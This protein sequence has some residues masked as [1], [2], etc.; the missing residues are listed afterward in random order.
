ML[1]NSKYNQMED[2]KNTYF[3]SFHFPSF[4][5][6]I[7]YGNKISGWL[8]IKPTISLLLLI[9]NKKKTWKLM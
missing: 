4:L 5:F 9:I 7:N 8:I 3:D 2:R 6:L 1:I